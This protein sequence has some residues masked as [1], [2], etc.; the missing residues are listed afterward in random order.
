MALIS[1]SFINNEG[2]IFNAEGKKYYFFIK[3]IVYSI[4]VLDYMTLRT[5]YRI[6]G[7]LVGCMVACPRNSN[8]NGNKPTS[9]S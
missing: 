6:I 7:N 3:I 8:F 5:K 1:V 4:L 2:F 9:F